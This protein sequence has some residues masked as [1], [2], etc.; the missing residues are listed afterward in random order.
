VEL[1]FGNWVKHRRKTLD[2]TQQ[3]LAERVG[4]SVSLI[5][6]IE[7]DER[8]PSRQIAELLAEWLEILPDQRTLFLKVARQEK[9]IQNLEFI[10]LPSAQSPAL[11]TNQPQSNLPLPTTSLI[12]REYE[13]DMVLQQLLNPSC[14]LLT[15][16]GPGGVGKTR[17]ALEVAHRLRDVFQHGV[18]FVPLVS[19]AAAEF[20]FPGIAD[21]LGFPVA[22][23]G[24]VKTQLFRFLKGKSVLLVLDNFEHLMNGAE[25]LAELL[26]SGAEIKLF[27]TSREPLNLRAEWTFTVQGLPIPTNI[28]PEQLESNSAAALFLQR[29]RQ[30]R[31]DFS[32][33]SVD[34]PHIERICQLVEGLPLGLELA[35]AWVRT[36]SCRE[37]AREIENNL[38]FLSS[39]ARDVPQ[40]HHSMRA[41]FD[42]SW[43]QLSAEEQNVLMRLSIFRGGFTREAAAQVCGAR[44]P[45]LSALV[46]KSLIRHNPKDRYDLH[47]LIR[48]YA[49][50]WLIRSGDFE[51]ARNQH[52]IFFLTLVEEGKQKASG[53]EQILWLDR[54][55]ED[56]DNLRTA[57]EWALKSEET[58]TKVSAN[59]ESLTVK[60]ALRLAGELHFFWKRRSH[61]AEGREWL[62]RALAQCTC[63]PGTPERLIA[64]NAAALL[65]VEQAD[66]KSASEYAQ[67][68][69]R[70]SQ[71]LEDSHI[72]A[73]AFNTLGLVRWK[74]KKYAEARDLCEQGLALFREL[75]DRFGIA[76][77]LHS[78]GHITINQ[79][80]LEVAQSYLDES[81]VISQGLENKIGFAEALGDLGLVAYLRRDYV[82]AQ[83]YLEES[84]NR[85]QEANLLPGFVSA[86]NRL[87]DL[88]RCQGDYERADQLYKESLS[89]YR[90]MGDLDEIPSLLHNL[91]YTAQHR[92]DPHR[93]RA[94]FREALSIQQ[95]MNNRAGVAECLM[96]IAGVLATLRHEKNGA[97]LLGAAE[98]LRVS[99]GA[100]LWPANCL[101]Y[102]CILTLLK[103]SLDEQTFAAAW[104]DGQSLTIEQAI[105]EAIV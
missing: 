76:E 49:Q 6:K 62:Q 32:L 88:A 57:L 68:N 28:S 94:L 54:L 92:N 85:F 12:G 27:V 2:L 9:G 39:A 78:L 33:S 83:S 46:D 36:L 24:D 80:D 59:R 53:T 19:T 61:W 101:E 4:C 84:M 55:E 1:S 89:L 64:L 41:V 91:A 47:E 14:R 100:S 23:A 104:A 26:E 21:S 17:L 86:L 105:A 8:R 97:R 70:L 40:R 3:E 69:L 30:A 87:G 50:G 63:L 15:L 81:L 95:K 42:S 35:A 96:G 51:D 29:A 65:A 31:L 11:V 20:I 25:L 37:I 72:R 82:T 34:F 5:F 71:E 45:I 79:N 22:N 77:A 102:D 93:A 44:L 90:E 74:Q 56:H 103:E 10:S 16:T 98:A 43:H 52:F 7:S 99:V 18:Y 13:V 60:D 48:Q 58:G 75:G 67:E 73:T 66:T 38:D